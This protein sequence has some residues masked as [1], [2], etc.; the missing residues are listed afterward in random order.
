[1]VGIAY[2]MKLGPLGVEPVDGVHQSEPRD[3][4]QVLEIFAAAAEVAGYVIG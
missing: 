1:M 3:L 2:P 4:R